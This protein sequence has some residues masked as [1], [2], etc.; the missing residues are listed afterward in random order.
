[1]KDYVQS[2][3]LTK[4]D[5]FAVNRDEVIDLE[6]WFKI[7][8]NVCNVIFLQLFIFHNLKVRS[9]YLGGIRCIDVSGDGCTVVTGGEDGQVVMWKIQV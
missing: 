5:P 7:R 3:H 6:T 8:T 4:F 2:F 9:T 1:M